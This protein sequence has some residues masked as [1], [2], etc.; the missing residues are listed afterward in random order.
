[1]A[2]EDRVIEQEVER[3]LSAMKQ[4]ILD[5]KNPRELMLAHSQ[6]KF[7]SRLELLPLRAGYAGSGCIGDAVDPVVTNGPNIDSGLAVGGAVNPGVMYYVGENGNERIAKKYVNE[8][9]LEVT[10]KIDRTTAR[11]I[12]AAAGRSA[13]FD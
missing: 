2:V 7:S 5:S 8:S 12:A 6:V 4:E 11:E 13:K 9:F 10:G 1:M 3:F